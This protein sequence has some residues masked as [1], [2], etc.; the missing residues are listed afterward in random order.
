[1]PWWAGC[2]GAAA[3]LQ[4]AHHG[5]QAVLLRVQRRQQPLQLDRPAP[6]VLRELARSLQVYERGRALLAHAELPADP[7]Y[8]HALIGA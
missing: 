4:P 6:E 8:I 2:S 1:M 7:L 5:P 3:P